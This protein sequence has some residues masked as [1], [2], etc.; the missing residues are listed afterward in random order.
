MVRYRIANNDGVIIA[1][2]STTEEAFKARERITSICGGVDRQEERLLSITRVD[3]HY[4]VIDTI[5]G[6]DCIKTDSA[7]E[8]LRIRNVLL[9]VCAE[10]IKETRPDVNESDAIEYAEARYKIKQV[11]TLGDKE[12]DN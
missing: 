9:A 4:K 11:E 3:V 8:A 1:E 7:T 2:Y 12:D 5:A 6:H 10:W